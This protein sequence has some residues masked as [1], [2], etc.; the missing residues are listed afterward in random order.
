VLARTFTPIPTFSLTFVFPRLILFL[1]FE[2]TP[3]LLCKIKTAT[4]LI[5]PT[6]GKAGFGF[7]V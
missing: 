4:E 3:I 7:S 5:S 6:N 1:D 2:N